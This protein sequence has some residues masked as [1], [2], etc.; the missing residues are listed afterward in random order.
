M[1]WL[2]RVF[3]FKFYQ[4][5]WN[6]TSFLLQII[7]TFLSSF[8]NLPILSVSMFLVLFVFYSRLLFCFS[9][10][11]FN[12]KLCFL[13]SQIF[14]Q[15]SNNLFLFV[16][17]FCFSFLFAPSFVYSCLLFTD[18]FPFYLSSTVQW[19]NFLFYSNIRTWNSKKG[20]H[21]DKLLCY[22]DKGCEMY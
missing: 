10:F 16:S 4:D 1:G 8:Q 11:F 14:F 13:L 19:S 15:S 3:V 6:T 20:R 7:M 21:S 12:F 9:Q 5:H 17:L 2:C 22:A 18:T